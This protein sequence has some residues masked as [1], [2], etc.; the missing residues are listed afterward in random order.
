MMKEN[1]L[2]Y[3]LDNNIPTVGTRIQSSWPMVTEVVGA[4]GEYDYI[5]FLAEYAPFDTYDLENIARAAEV[6]N[7][8]SMIKVDYQ[9]RFFVAQKAITSGF[10]AVMFTDH[11]TAEAVA[12]TIDKITPECPGYD[13]HMGFVNRRWIGNN[14][15]MNQDD[16][17]KMASRTVKVF[18]IE[19]KEAVAN[20]DEIC[21]VPGVDMIQFGPNDFALSSGFNM[22][23]N[24]E[25]IRE[26]EQKIIETALKHGVQPRA[27]MNT[28][29]DLKYYMDLGVRHFNVGMQLRI[30]S[31]YWKQQGGEANT[32]LREAG[33]K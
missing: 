23:E 19:K 14:F 31:N 17:A 26:V 10:Q 25:R 27:E 3:K 13:G 20:I 1:L 4:T 2:R 29:E 24:K 11:R 15:S 9:N 32:L 18:M 21:S 33:L 16:Y 6:H 8:A 28:V 22:A 5:E 7:M 30:L 12:D